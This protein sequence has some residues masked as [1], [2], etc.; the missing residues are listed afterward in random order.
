MKVTKEFRQISMRWA[1]GVFSPK[2]TCE[3]KSIHHEADFIQTR[4][5]RSLYDKKSTLVTGAVLYCI[6]ILSN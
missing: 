3:G 2:W 5:F 1:W 6:A 4:S